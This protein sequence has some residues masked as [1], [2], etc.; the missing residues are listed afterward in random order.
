MMEAAYRAKS[1][2]CSRLS[3][4]HGPFKTSLKE[5]VGDKSGI[6]DCLGAFYMAKRWGQLSSS[7]TTFCSF[8]IK[9][10]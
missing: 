8:P 9:I 7:D 3:E 4:C 5:T 1:L 6:E 2:E 10:R